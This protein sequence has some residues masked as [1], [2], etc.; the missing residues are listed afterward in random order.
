MPTYPHYASDFRRVKGGCFDDQ[1]C[2]GRRGVHGGLTTVQ[3]RGVPQNS[4]REDI[5]E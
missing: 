2:A 3:V 5:E 1:L 4:Q